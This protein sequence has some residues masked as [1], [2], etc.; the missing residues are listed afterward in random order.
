VRKEARKLGFPS[1]YTSLRLMKDFSWCSG[2]DL[3]CSATATYSECAA[4]IFISMLRVNC[5]LT[6]TGRSLNT[7]SEWD[8]VVEGPWPAFQ[9]GSKRDL[10]VS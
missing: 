5:R 4:A 10:S 3:D 9:R 2:S 1:L 7:A 8:H 6:E